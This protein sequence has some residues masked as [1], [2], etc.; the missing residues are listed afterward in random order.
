MAKPL[1]LPSA[2]TLPAV[3]LEQAARQGRRAALRHKRLGVWRERNW[4]E[5]ADEVGRLAAA[6]AGL[7]VTQ[8]VFMAAPHQVSGALV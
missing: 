4:A 7:G 6:L 1:T 8:L 3:L 5:L 2:A